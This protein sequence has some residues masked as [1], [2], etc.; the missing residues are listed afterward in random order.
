MS[1]DLIL[2]MFI[3]ALN[4]TNELSALY[5]KAKTENRT[6]TDAELQAVF[7]KDAVARAKL[8]LD[9]AAAKAAGK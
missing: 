8:T 2:A 3:A 7:D 4:H 1:A 9:I 6:I 5:L